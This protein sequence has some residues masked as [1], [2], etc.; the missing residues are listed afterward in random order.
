MGIVW[1]IVAGLFLAGG[2]YFMSRAARTI[3]FDADLRAIVLDV[4]QNRYVYLFLVF[5]LCATVAYLLCLRQ[6]QLIDGFTVTTVAMSAAVLAIAITILRIQPT[7]LQLVGFVM[8]VA[9]VVLVVR[10]S[11]A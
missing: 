9:G 6:K 4:L 7:A 11:A 1:G 10:G 3:E 5:N 8:A 2:H